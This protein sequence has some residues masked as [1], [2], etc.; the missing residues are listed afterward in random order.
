MPK[1]LGA[2][3]GY[4]AYDIPTRTI[5]CHGGHSNSPRGSWTLNKVEGKMSSRTRSHAQ[6]CMVA[7]S[8]IDAKRCRHTSTAMSRRR[9]NGSQPVIWTGGCPSAGAGFGD[10][11]GRG[12][13]F[14]LA[15]HQKKR[16]H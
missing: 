4:D 12:F 11:V 15:K 8:D 1:K 3:H 5:Q 9:P 10:S 13:R 14:G 7:Y 6:I 2:V 16:S